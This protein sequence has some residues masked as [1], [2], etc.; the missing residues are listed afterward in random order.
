M[1]ADNR[2]LSFNEETVLLMLDADTAATLERHFTED[3]AHADE[4]LLAT[5]RQRGAWDRVKEHVTHLVWRV[6]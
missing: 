5:F 1:N 4:I 6:L 3:T 2:S